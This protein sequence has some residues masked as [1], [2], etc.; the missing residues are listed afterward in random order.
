M[1]C[2]F[3]AFGCC[4]T[5]GETSNPLLDDRK[6][7]EALP[8]AENQVDLG[9]DLRELKDV[10]F[11]T[12]GGMCSIYTA[13]FRGQRVVVKIPRDNC[14]QP[15]VACKDLETEV[16]ILTR[17]NHPNIIK[18]LGA[19]YVS[20]LDVDGDGREAADFKDL[21]Q[22]PKRF[23][24]LEYLSGGTLTEQMGLGQPQAEGVVGSVVRRWQ[25]SW[26]FP[27]KKALESA[28]QLASALNYLHS[29]AVDEGFVVHRDLKPENIAF[30]LDGRLKLF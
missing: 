23:V 21:D 2:F 4:C 27:T 14:A 20:P 10:H 15:E 24:L 30:T 5:T 12:N 13:E 19:G 8:P 6:S 16:D 3:S 1:G 18:V 28:S 25:Q 11:L 7:R 17:L 22:P 26:Q 9:L 29:G